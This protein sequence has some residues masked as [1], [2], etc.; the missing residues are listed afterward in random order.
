MI[1]RF[2][3]TLIELL[4]VIAIIAIL[5]G[6]LVPAVQKV[7]AAAARTECSNNL[8]QLVLAINAYEEAAKRLPPATVSQPKQNN[9][10]PFLFPYI[11]EGSRVRNY[12]FDLGWWISPNREVVAT[13][14]KILN[15]PAT[16]VQ[17]R[18]QD[19]PESTPPNKTGACTDYF[20][21]LGVHADINKSL[22]ATDQYAATADLRG[23]MVAC[24][25]TQQASRRRE[26]K[27]GT[28]NTFLMAECAGR[29]DVW[30]RNVMTP[31]NFSGPSPARARG[32]AWATTDNPY[33][34][35]Q[36]LTWVPSGST[37]GEIP[38]DIA[39]N[40]SNEWGHAFYS[41]HSGGANFAFVDGSVRFLTEQAS[42]K[43]LA[44][45]ATRSGGE[46]TPAE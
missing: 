23:A 26:I 37:A 16:F 36:K 19:K 31:N 32:G 12:R 24:P 17:N 39:I 35:G 44:A 42:L 1:R 8:K 21:P 33:A 3:F 38:G 29:E 45:L 5:I 2:A 4:V 11:E 20:P 6:L 22:A 14:I 15:C 28:S 30:R 13:Q 9:W 34:I 18:M 46:P 10:A 7:R 40:N 41:F 43:S 25:T 27:D